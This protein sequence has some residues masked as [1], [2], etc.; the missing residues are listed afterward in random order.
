MYDCEAD[1]HDE[2]SFTEGEV[3]V[4]LGEEDTDWWVGSPG[5]ESDVTEGQTGRWV[6]CAGLESVCP[7][8]P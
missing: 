5:L 2:L 8:I 1:H 4:V 6:G 7:E 3:L